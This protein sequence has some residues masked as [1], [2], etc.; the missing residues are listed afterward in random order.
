MWCYLFFSSTTAEPL[1][2][3]LAPPPNPNNSVNNDDLLDHTAGI[4]NS[5]PTKDPVTSPRKSPEKICTVA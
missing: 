2:L 1:D 5:N 4:E 3:T